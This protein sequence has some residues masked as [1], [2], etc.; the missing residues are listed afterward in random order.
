MTPAAIPTC[1]APAAQSLPVSCKTTSSTI[2]TTIL[3]MSAHRG[4]GLAK[5]LYQGPRT[6]GEK[7]ALG[8]SKRRPALSGTD[9]G[10]D[11]KSAPGGVATSFN[12]TPQDRENTEYS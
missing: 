3:P 10:T 1:F 11:R 5:A 7:G 8:D 4:S 2:T 9:G 12:R 6:R